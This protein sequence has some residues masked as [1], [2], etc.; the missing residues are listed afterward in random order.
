MIF[1]DDLTGLQAV[2]RTKPPY[3]IKGKKRF[4]NTTIYL[5]LLYL[6]S[7]TS[8]ARNLVH[9]QSFYPS[10]FISFKIHF[11]NDRRLLF[12]FDLQSIAI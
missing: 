8:I 4:N 1:V 3:T 7:K 5:Y 12:A 6:I 11:H 2:Q 10:I 9:H